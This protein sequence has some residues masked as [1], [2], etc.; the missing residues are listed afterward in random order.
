MPAGRALAVFFGPA[1]IS[2]GPDPVPAGPVNIV[3]RIREDP[4]L[5]RQA[6]GAREIRIEKA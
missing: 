1:P 4:A 3:G 5:L 6:K 2:T